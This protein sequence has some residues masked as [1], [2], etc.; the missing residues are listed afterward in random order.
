MN[1]LLLYFEFFKIGLFAVGGGLATLPFLFSMAD[2][3]D[4][5]DREMVGNFLAIAQ[6]APGAIG[7]NMAAQTGFQACGI[8]GGC[9][10]PLGLISP[11]IIVIVIIARVLTAVKNNKIAAA[12][13]DG[14][15]PAG[16]GL[17][18]TAGFGALQLAL[19]NSD[20]AV[21]YE[22]L[23]IKETI[24]LAVLLLLIYKLK[25]HPVIYIAIGAIAGIAL[26]L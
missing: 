13:F 26:K 20:A 24:I 17:L 21:W 5:L 25:G 8:V 23:R 15:R 3:Y 11:A 4:W 9:I 16:A 6:S 14:L 10:A 2:N 1:L 18:T 22:F 12:V 7:V 19:V